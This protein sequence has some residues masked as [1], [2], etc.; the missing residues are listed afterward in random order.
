MARG[1]PRSFDRE[2]A[3]EQAMLI[4]WTKGF[5]STSL[6]D[7]TSALNINPPSFYAAFGS[8]ES[9]YRDVLER[10]HLEIGEK[11][12][13][14]LLREGPAFH[15]V[16]GLLNN[17]ARYLSGEKYPKGCLL[18][19]SGMEGGLPDNL[20]DELRRRRHEMF[21]RLQTRLL[22]AREENEISPRADCEAAARFYFT[23]QQGMVTRARDGE[24]RDQLEKTA[25]SAMLLW[26]VLLPE[27][28]RAGG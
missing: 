9:L 16:E 26:P 1:R 15:A 4:F 2:A 21:I 7:L 22:A 20:S 13:G 12:W 8:K 23:V 6:N 27:A 14:G 25:K 5:T 17:T 3:I 19:L 28:I 18:S 11:L 24:T 10:Y